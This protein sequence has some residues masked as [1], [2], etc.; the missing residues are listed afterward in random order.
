[1]HR[2]VTEKVVS[3]FEQNQIKNIQFVRLSETWCETSIYEI[4]LSYLLPTDFHDRVLATYKEAGQEPPEKYKRG[5][6]LSS[7]L[8]SIGL[9]EKRR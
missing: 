2:I 7:I 1:M 8:R 6:L 5:N 3:T 4:G 9:W